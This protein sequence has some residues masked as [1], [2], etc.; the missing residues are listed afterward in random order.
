VKEMHWP[1]IS[2][3]KQS[4]LEQIK[5]TLRSQKIKRTTRELK[6]NEY[7]VGRLHPLGSAKVKKERVYS[8][9]EDMSVINHHS[10]VDGGNSAIISGM[11]SVRDGGNPYKPKK[12]INWKKLNINNPQIPPLPN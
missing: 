5:E 8:D 9:N 4:E 2:E 10:E 1:K 3:K 11:N 6:E 7:S 12:K